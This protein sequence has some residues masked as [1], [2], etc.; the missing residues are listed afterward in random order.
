MVVWPGPA[1]QSTAII[2][3]TSCSTDPEPFANAQHA[4]V[5]HIT[6]G[7]FPV[8]LLPPSPNDI[9]CFLG[10]ASAAFAI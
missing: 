4:H 1:M 2:N 7:A 9:L 5:G 8:S 10:Q 6:K 3:S